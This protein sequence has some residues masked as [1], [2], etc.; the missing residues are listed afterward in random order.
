VQAGAFLLGGLRSGNTRHIVRAV[1]SIF[2]IVIFVCI[3]TFFPASQLLAGAAASSGW[4]E[5][6]GDK[7]YLAGIGHGFHIFDLSDPAHPKWMGGWQNRTCPVGVQVVGGFAYVANRTSGFEVIDVHNATA[8]ALVGHL[9]TG[10]DLQTVQVVGHYAYVADLRRG[11]DIIDISD[12]AKPKLAGD[13]ETKGQGWSVV[14][15][16]DYLYA[17]Y[18][19][20]VLRIFQLDHGTA[21]MLVKEI[22]GAGSMGMLVADGKLL[23]QQFGWLCLMSLQ[24]PTNPVMIADSQIGFGMSGSA[25]VRDSLVFMTRGKMALGIFDLGARGKIKLLGSLQAG[26][27][28]YGVCVWGHFA[29][30]ADGGANLHVID[31]SDPTKPVEVNR[32]GTENFCSKVL[33]L[34]DGSVEKSAMAA[35]GNLGGPVTN[36]PPELGNAVRVVDGAFSFTLHGVPGGVYYLQASTDLITWKVIST[37]TLSDG[38]T[39]RISDPDAHL[40]SNRFYRA[41]KKE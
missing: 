28:G 5:I 6:A 32:I 10:G 19:G 21:P 35:Q 27:Q 22:S 31:I 38:G 11:L 17:G 1:K 37:N 34:T 33:S 20:G 23:T 30:V 4:L 29:Y 8:P 26:Y 40:F 2:H 3:A 13:F 9:R 41:V 12:P 36:A 25:C 16:G 14:A 7:L 39:L 15:N 24:N 18:G